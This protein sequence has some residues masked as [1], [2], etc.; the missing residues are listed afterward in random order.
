MT[1]FDK[2]AMEFLPRAERIKREKEM[3]LQLHASG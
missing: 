3:S 1:S 2:C